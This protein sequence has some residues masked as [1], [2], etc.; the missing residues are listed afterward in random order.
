MLVGGRYLLGEPVGQGELSRVWHARDELLGRAVAVKEVLRG[1]WPP[2]ERAELV[3]RAMRGAQAAAQLAWHP[4]VITI[5]DVVE[6]GGAPWIVMELVSGPSLRAEIEARGRLPWQRV[7]GIGRQV[8]DALG[9]AHAA[10]IV[11]GD[12]KPANILLADRGAIVADFGIARILDGIAGRTRPGMTIAPHYTAPEQLDGTPGAPADLWALGATLYTA[13]EGSPPFQADSLPA[14]VAAILTRPLAPA[15]H[16]GPLGDLIEALLATDPGQRPSPQAVVDALAAAARQPGTASPPGTPAAASTPATTAAS[17]PATTAA[18]TPATTAASTRVT[19]A[20]TAQEHAETG[21]RV[22]DDG[23]QAESEAAR[24]EALFREAIRRNPFDADDHCGLGDA[25]QEAGRYREAEDAYREAIRLDPFDVFGARLGLGNSLRAAGRYRE[26]EA[27]YR[28]AIDLNPDDADAHLG[29][30]NALQDAGRHSEAEAPFREAIRLGPE[31]VFG[32]HLGLGNSLRARQRN[33]EAEAAYREAILRNPEDSS[34]HDQLGGILLGMTRYAEAEAAYREAMRLNPDGARGRPY[35]NSV[36]GLGQVFRA[37]Q[38]HPE[39]EAAFLE[40]VRLDPYNADAHDVL[41]HIFWATQRYPEAEAAFRA[42]T[43][44]DRK[45]AYAHH[46]LGAALVVM[47][48]YAEAEVAFGEAIRHAVGKHRVNK[49]LG[50][51]ALWHGLAPRRRL[52][53][54]SARPSAATRAAPTRT[55][56]SA[57]PCCT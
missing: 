24:R 38:R 32:A 21:E 36:Y 11:H 43:D 17:T 40:T 46:G 39:A 9:H 37:M 42:V 6:F 53:P 8:A 31:D 25:L 35:A 57:T 1:W 45:D 41:G 19:P 13:V 49:L 16:A 54:S 5:H 2:D 47:A 34:A 3:A 30:G 55:R 10:G 50:S 18:S 26:A 56:A 20:A 12:L 48:R 23:R 33:Q 28:E 15:Q 14:M 52:R 29:L 22:R 4:G 51:F 7:A 27:A 44:L